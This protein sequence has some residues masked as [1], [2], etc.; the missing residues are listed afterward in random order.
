MVL[1]TL[2]DFQRQQVLVHVA[3]GLSGRRAV[4]PAEG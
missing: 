3:G 4:D 1:Q 2:Q